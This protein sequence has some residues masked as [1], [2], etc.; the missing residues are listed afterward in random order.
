MLARVKLA[1]R[2]ATNAYDAELLD[3][4]AAAAVDIAHAGA[5]IEVT[6][7]ET[8]GVVTDYTCTDPLTRTAIVTYCRVHFGA[9]ADY[10]RL[11][12]SYD[13]QKGQMRESTAYGMVEA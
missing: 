3:L 7:V 1:L 2:V 8:D 12:A 10:E 6:P 11:K 9:P 4:I 13:E 5:V